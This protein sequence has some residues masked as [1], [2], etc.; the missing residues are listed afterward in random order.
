[1]LNIHTMRFRLIVLAVFATV[2]GTAFRL[3]VV[4]PYLKAQIREQ[5]AA[6]QLSIANYVAA[7]VGNAVAMRQRSLANLAQ[8]GLR[9][10]A[11]PGR[12][13]QAWIADRQHFSLR[14]D[15]GLVLIAPDGHGVLAQ[16]PMAEARAHVDFAQYDW[17][18]AAVAAPAGQVVQPMHWSVDPQ[19][20]I[21][22]ADALRDPNGRLLGVLAGLS[23]LQVPDFLGLLQQKHLGRT[24]GFLLVAPREKLFIASTDPTMTLRPT[25]QAGVDVLHDRAMAGYRGSDITINAKGVEELS[26]IA[27]VP[28]TDWFV[29][30]R[31]PTDEAFASV[32][33]MR[34]VMWYSSVVIIL[35]ILTIVLTIFTRML[36]P[37]TTTAS[38][39]RD[40][41]DGKREL[42]PLPVDTRDEVSELV[43]GFNYLVERLA[44]KDAA[45]HAS[46]ARLAFMAHHDPLTGLPNRAML[47]DRL[48]QAMARVERDGTQLALLFCDLDGFKPINDQFG[49]RA[50]D[51]VLRE[52]ADRLRLGRR[53]TDTVARLGGD[54]FIVLLADLDDARAASSLVAEQCL[55]AIREPIELDG[56]HFDVGMSVGIALHAG[57]RVA[58]SE[59]LS[60]ADIGMY[61]AK[62]AGK[63]LFRFFEVDP[64]APAGEDTATAP[65]Q[66][67]P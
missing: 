50:G 19:P 29:V 9:V 64:P 21:V 20:A 65:D 37:L 8:D 30:A 58:T 42:A 55:A 36:R 23:S 17:F 63:G 4:L 33:E 27:S 48:E 54:E 47:E 35:V 67:R 3:V 41:A 52:V 16:Y 40:I 61:H 15:L 57:A 44:E 11:Q 13:T 46:E 59:L 49:H 24:G 45:L 10:L 51:A 18:H 22:T 56:Q 31:V 14:F 39:M 43:R 25:P 28:G 2:L 66:L 5:Y 62:R 53:R 1:M 32:A 38:L 6:Q 26:S 7:D 12:D 60:Q 34:R